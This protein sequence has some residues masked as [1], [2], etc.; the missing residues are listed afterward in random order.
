M[1]IHGNMIY[2]KII[3]SYDPYPYRIGLNTTKHGCKWGCKGGCDCSLGYVTLQHVFPR[4]RYGTKIC[5]ITVPK[6]VQIIQIGNNGKFK[7]DK[8]IIEK[9]IPIWEIETIQYL[10]S[11]GAGSFHNGDTIIHTDEWVLQWASAHGLLDV[12]QYLAFIGINIYAG[13]NEALRLASEKGHLKIVQYLVS[14]GANTYSA[15]HMAAFEGHLDIVQYLV[16]MGDYIHSDVNRAFRLVSERGH[17]DVVKYLVSIGANIHSEDDHALRWASENGHLE[18]VQ[19]LVSMGANVDADDGWPIQTASTN[20]HL[21]IVQYL[22]SMG[23]DINATIS[24]DHH[25]ALV[26]AIR[27]G[28]LKVAQYLV[29][30]G[31]NINTIDDKDLQRAAERGYLDMVHYVRILLRIRSYIFR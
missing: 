25:C 9:M 15:L 24:G 19:Y 28:R 16:S 13:N 21:K 23:A 3:K 22:V 14:M 1:N 10:M 20:G 2:F 12:V 30:N 29:S 4:M 18:V 5:I 8:F 27:A 7:C 11:I 26:R 17:L 6:D 31:A